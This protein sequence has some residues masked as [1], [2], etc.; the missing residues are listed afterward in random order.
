MSRGFRGFRGL[1][2]RVLGEEMP[3]P[4]LELRVTVSGSGFEGFWGSGF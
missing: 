4:A 3:K 2:F 1:G